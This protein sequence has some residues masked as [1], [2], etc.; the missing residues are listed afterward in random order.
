M[1]PEPVKPCFPDECSVPTKRKLRQDRH[2]Q[3]SAS[4]VGRIDSPRS[5]PVERVLQC[6]LTLPE[7][8]PLFTPHGI[9]GQW[10]LR[11]E[12]YAGRTAIV[13]GTDV[14]PSPGVWQASIAHDASFAAAKMT[15]VLSPVGG[16]LSPKDIVTSKA[17]RNRLQAA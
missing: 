4:Q 7:R 5:S 8:R 16:P 11:Q 1:D 6:S 13:A 15:G 14:A 2:G 3:R 10:R 9:F 17:E 12:L